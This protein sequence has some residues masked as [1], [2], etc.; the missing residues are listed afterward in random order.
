MVTARN[1]A[2][3]GSERSLPSAVAASLLAL[4]VFAGGPW[5]LQHRPTH[6][7]L[8]WNLA[9]QKLIV[10]GPHDA[11]QPTFALFEEWVRTHRDLEGD[12]A[13]T[14]EPI[15]ATSV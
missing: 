10:F 13:L 2:R 12:A 14:I 15:E 7:Y 8:L 11:K 5:L 1:L 9:H 6:R 4:A 3:W